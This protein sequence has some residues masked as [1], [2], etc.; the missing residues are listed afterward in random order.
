MKKNE[1]LMMLTAASVA[2][3]LGTGGFYQLDSEQGWATCLYKAIQLFSMNSGVVESKDT[4]LLIEIS[5]WL[6]PFAVAG[7]VYSTVILFLNKWSDARRLASLSDHA[8]V[9]GVGN[10]GSEIARAFT[11]TGNRRVVI[12]EMDEHNPS[13]GELRNLAEAGGA[14]IHVITAN[15]LDEAVL[16]R[17]GVQKA[18]SL[19]A[20]TGHDQKNLSICAEA[21]KLN[22]FLCLSAGI[23]SWAWRSYYLDRLRSRIRLDS[24][25]SRA[26]RNLTLEL[27]CD[28]AKEQHFRS[29]GVRVV[30]EAS[31]NV[32]QELVRAAALNFQISGDKRPVLEITAANEEDV[33]TFNDRFPASDLVVDIR[34]HTKTASQVFPEGSESFPD[35]A[36]FA[37][38]EDIQTL[39]AAERFW[40]RSP[41]KSHR[42]QACVRSESDSLEMP[43][44][45]RRPADFEI[46]NIFKLGLGSDD[47]TEI[48]LERSA[49]VCHRIY[50]LNE[51][52][53]KADYGTRQGDLP[54]EWEKLSER[55]RESNRLL[56]MHH[57][58]K[59]I[60][61]QAR[62]ETP[63]MEVLTHL[64]RCEH[65]RWMAEKAMDGWRWTGPSAPRDNDR[66]KHPL[67]VRY[68]A[69]DNAEKDKDYNA[70]LW[71]LEIPEPGLAELDLEEGVKRRVREQTTVALQYMR[72]QP[73]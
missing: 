54:E 44:V 58:V 17:A 16:A 4:P 35:F 15:A 32:R 37:Y 20:V 31:P 62:G 24:Y 8:I 6:A 27:A 14:E 22:Q 55:T 73:A 47:P 9:C 23:E 50:F 30:I 49:Q 5:R 69:L 71:A 61:W 53:K 57:E 72:R 33:A 66:L 40:M 45:E 63:S 65:M 43:A 59:R 3:L 48:S 51:Q 29:H 1:P 70:F 25:L 26:A 42:I 10:R 12:I 7:A 2:L 46:K 52:L 18:R 39:E 28:A 13:L 38:D 56:A 34:W 21:E 19:V 41:I 60:A 68:D 36:V 67:L 64:S 11:R